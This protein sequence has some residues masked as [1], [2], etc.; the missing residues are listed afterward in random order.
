LI[1]VAIASAFIIPI[2]WVF[3]W[4]MGWQLSQTELIERT[5]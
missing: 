4:I 5:A 3:R 1:V 2:P